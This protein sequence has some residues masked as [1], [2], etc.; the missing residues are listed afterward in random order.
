MK[1]IFYCLLF[2]TL[3]LTL[4]TLAASA[5]IETGV[6]LNSK[7]ENLL[8]NYP[9]YGIKYEL[10]TDTG[11]LTI[12]ST[13]GDGAMLSHANK[14]WVPWLQG[15]LA[16]QVQK[17]VIEPGVLSIGRYAFYGCTNLEEVYIPSTVQKID[18]AVFFGCSALEKIYYQGNAVDFA[19]KVEYDESQNF[20]TSDMSDTARARFVFGESVRVNCQNQDGY[21]FKTYTVGGYFEGDEFVIVPESL[22]GMSFVGKKSEI[23]GSFRKGEKR[24]FVLEYECTHDYETRDLGKPCGV[25]CTHCGGVDP[26]R[27]QDHHWEYSENVTR[28]LFRSESVM[29]K[30]T[31]CGATD[32]S[33]APAYALYVGIALGGL[34]VLGGIALAVILPFKR[35]KKLKELTW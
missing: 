7:V 20:L 17:V 34:L 33:T 22:D 6:A 32:A 24:E 19:E 8:D 16:Q 3:C 27:E 4:L 11:V 1:K 35:R 2:V 31:I 10:D 9:D 12:Y 26:A 30:C 28:G 15:T 21:I 14:E 18:A 23:K 29:R 5:K 25:F 13:N